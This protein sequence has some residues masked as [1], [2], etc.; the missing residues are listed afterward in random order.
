MFGTYVKLHILTEL[1]EIVETNPTCESDDLILKVLN[2]DLEETCKSE[3]LNLLY[4]YMKDKD[5]LPFLKYVDDYV[6]FFVES[7]RPDEDDIE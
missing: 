5:K 2:A 3:I 4:G 6:S 7:M 1:C